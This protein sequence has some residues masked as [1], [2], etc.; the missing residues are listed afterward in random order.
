MKKKLPVVLKIIFIIVI[1]FITLES[2]LKIR[3]TKKAVTHALQ[4][5]TIPGLIYEHKPSITFTNRHGIEVTYNSMGFIGGEIPEK[6]KFRILGIGDSIMAGEYLPEAD[7]FLNRVGILLDA[8][9]INAAVSGYNTWQELA[10]IK[11][12]LP[13]K[14]DFIIV[15]VCL[16]DYWRGKPVLKMTRFG[17]LTNSRDGASARYFDFIYQRSDLYKNHHKC[18]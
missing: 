11:K 12:C 1:A 7:T 17:L 4:L 8:E 13:L 6:E 15:A 16:N 10:M 14:P 18:H 5:A 2:G 9:V 3:N